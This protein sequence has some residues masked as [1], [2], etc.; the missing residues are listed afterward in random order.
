VNWKLVGTLSLFGAVMA[1]ATVWVVPAAIEPLLWLAIFA[2]CAVVIARS[3]HDKLF[4]HGL[5]VS[6]LNS[7]WITAA[8]VAFADAYL[9]RHPQEAAMSAGMGSPRLMM[10]MTGPVIGLVSGVV[11][12]GLTWVVGRF[13]KPR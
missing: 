7:V 4:L 6:L 10:V 9:A 11:L 3:R 2:I 13:V 5:C 12:G 1:L 8:H